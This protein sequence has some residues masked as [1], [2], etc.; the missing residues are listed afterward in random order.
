MDALEELQIWYRAQCDGDWEHSYGVKID[1]LDNPGWS[2]TV[3]LTDTALS[4]KPFAEK[5]YGTGPNAPTSG[6]EWL[7]CKVEN[8]QFLATG[9]PT[10][11][12]VMIT[13]FLAWASRVV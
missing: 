6:N 7:H 8:E 5:T 9:G 1:T 2:L 11:L 3:D 12:G 10:K 4:G 13:I